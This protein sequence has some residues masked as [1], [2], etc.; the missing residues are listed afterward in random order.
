M[1]LQSADALWAFV[2]AAEQNYVE[3]RAAA[4]Q[5]KGL[6]PVT[7][8]PKIWT[9]I[10]ELRREERAH[11]FGLKPHPLSSIALMPRGP[12]VE[13]SRQILGHAWTAPA[14]PADYPLTPKEREDAPW[15]WQVKEALRD[16]SAGLIPSTYSPLERDK[17][18]AYLS[19]VLTMPCGTD[20]EAQSF[21]EAVQG[22]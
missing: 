3:R 5:A 15:P 13:R 18:G 9:A 10:G 20:E 21:V 7:W 16:L 14:Q 6:V 19:A 22:S 17:A 1:A 4:Y 11:G 8:L 2:T 12:E